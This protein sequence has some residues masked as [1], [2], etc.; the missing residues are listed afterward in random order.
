MIEAIEWTYHYVMYTNNLYVRYRRCAHFCKAEADPYVEEV[1]AQ[2]CV[3]RQLAWA[4]RCS[5]C[6]QGLHVHEY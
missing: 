2:C 6:I 4:G 1:A 3:C 5:V